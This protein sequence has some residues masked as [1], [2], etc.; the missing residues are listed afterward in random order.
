MPSAQ[1]TTQK[2]K[3][4]IIQH[5]SYGFVCLDKIKNYY[6]YTKKRDEAKEFSSLY[7]CLDINLNRGDRI[8]KI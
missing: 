6:T 2:T 3:K 5:S 4:F 1:P 7:E 8:I